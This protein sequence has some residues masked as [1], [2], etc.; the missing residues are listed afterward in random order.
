MISSENKWEGRAL[1]SATL[2]G[3]G[4]AIDFLIAR[5]RD[6]GVPENTP[7][8][9]IYV[10]EAWESPGDAE[11]ALTVTFKWRTD[12]VLRGRSSGG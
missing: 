12:T 8:N 9:F 1:F 10:R 7:P 4:D 2:T 5:A 3:F 6:E 11:M